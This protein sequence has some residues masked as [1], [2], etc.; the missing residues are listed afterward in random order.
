[1]GVQ[2]LQFHS[3][4]FRIQR[5]FLFAELDRLHASPSVIAESSS[6]LQGLV[7]Y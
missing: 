3:R 4:L 5:E 7:V 6:R 2:A 1:M